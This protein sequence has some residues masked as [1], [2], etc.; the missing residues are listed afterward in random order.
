MKRA[1]KQLLLRAGYDLHRAKPTFIPFI[2]HYEFPGCAFNFWIAN[3]DATWWYGEEPWRV[4]GEFKELA[5]LVKKGDRV[6]EIGSHHGFT[7]LIFA[8]FVG[9]AGRVVG[10]EAHPWNAMIE[11][12][13]MGLNSS[14][15]NLQFINAAGSDRDGKVRVVAENHNSS[16][17]VGSAIATVEIPARTGDSLDREFG[18]FNFLK[19]DVEGYETTVL[20]GVQRPSA[21]TAKIGH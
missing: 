14:L 21:K 13:Q 10:V 17:G 1:L 20:K 4:S 15:K 5:R 12:A 16:M 3:Q 18:P 2:R 8:N 6:L 19:I 9:P 11:A 7:A